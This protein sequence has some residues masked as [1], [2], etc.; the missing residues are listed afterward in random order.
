MLATR[1]NRL[2]TLNFSRFSGFNNTLPQ[3]LCLLQAKTG[4]SHTMCT[5]TCLSCPHSR[6]SC[7]SVS[8]YINK[9][10]M[11]KYLI[12]YTCELFTRVQIGLKHSAV[13]KFRVTLQVVSYWTCLYRRYTEW[14]QN[15]W[16]SDQGIRFV[17]Y[18]KSAGGAAD[19]NTNNKPPNILLYDV[20]ESKL[21]TQ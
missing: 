5:L 11:I 20:T 10:L 12:H 4:Q 19:W 2:P 17:T 15:T 1:R 6:H 9:S 7:P 8:K 16:R 14:L 13:L 21:P 3:I 18:I